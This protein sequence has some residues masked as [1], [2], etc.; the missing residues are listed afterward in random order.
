MSGL[1]GLNEENVWKIPT[2]SEGK[3]KKKGMYD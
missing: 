1:K 2:N 3:K